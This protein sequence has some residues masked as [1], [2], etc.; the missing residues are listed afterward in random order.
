M[1]VP[2]C[3]PRSTRRC[4]SWATSAG[5]RTTGSGAIASADSASQSDPAHARGR[6]CLRS[7]DCLLR[8]E[9]R[10]P[11]AAAGSCRFR[12]RRD[13]R[14]TSA[15][16]LRRRW[17]CLSAAAQRQRRRALFP[18]A[19]A[20]HEDDARRGGV[21]MARALGFACRRRCAGSA[22]AYRR[23]REV[24]VPAQ[25]LPA[26][27]RRRR[28]SPSTTSAARTTSSSSRSGS[29]AG[30]SPGASSSPSSTDWRLRAGRWW[31][32]A[33]RRW[34]DADRWRRPG[35]RRIATTGLCRAPP[36]R[37]R[38]RGLVPPG[39]AAGCRPR[40]SGNARP[41][42]SHGFVWGEVWEWT[43]SPFAPYPGFVAHPYRDYSRRGSTAAG[44]CAAHRSRPGRACAI[45]ATATSSSR[46][47]RYLRRLSHL[48]LGLR[49][50][51]IG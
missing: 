50:G 45:R 5:F 18:P 24:E 34:R 21:Y 26:G 33:G 2:Y 38:G 13:P 29:T 12:T 51:V 4:G 40:P 15:A 42:R 36:Q 37:S 8:L 41:R 23:R 20:L 6:R 43:A 27:L 39:R 48:C 17:R 11:R 16:T 3:S 14:R 46:A 1:R 19:G 35:T 25:V 9:P 7:A 31:S 22:Q 30:P 28:A 47:H 32:R 10:R 44:C 49:P